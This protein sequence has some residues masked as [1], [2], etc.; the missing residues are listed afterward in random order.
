MLGTESIPLQKQKAR[1][2][3]P[4]SG[5]YSRRGG[6]EVDKCDNNSDIISLYVQTSRCQGLDK[7]CLLQPVRA[8]DFPHS[9]RGFRFTPPI[10]PSP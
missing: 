6:E 5:L 2:A 8:K 9:S 7:T 4:K 1:E 10:S 3:I